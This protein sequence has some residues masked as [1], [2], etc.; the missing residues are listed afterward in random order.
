MPFPAFDPYR[1]LPVFTSK[2]IKLFATE[3]VRIMRCGYIRRKDWSTA[4][5]EWFLT[6][7]KRGVL[8]T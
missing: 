6:V 3:D 4:Q 2:A 1:G 5:K 8:Q 7:L